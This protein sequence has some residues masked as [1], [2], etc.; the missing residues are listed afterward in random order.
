M[1][2]TCSHTQPGAG[3]G[4]RFASV[5]VVPSLLSRKRLPRQ[6]QCA[7]GKAD[8]CSHL[9]QATQLLPSCCKVKDHRQIL[10]QLSK[11][12]DCRSIG[13]RQAKH[14]RNQR[15]PTAAALPPTHPPTRAHCQSAAS[16]QVRSL[17]CFVC[18][19]YLAHFT[20]AFLLDTRRPFLSRHTSCLVQL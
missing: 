4:A 3:L 19:S 18:H 6:G 15:P 8:L 16:I 1:S 7:F 17:T 13:P 5:S 2:V 10:Q 12:S 14:H 20:M 9:S 11:R